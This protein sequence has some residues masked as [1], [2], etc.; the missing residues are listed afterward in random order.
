MYFHK[1][2][3]INKNLENLLN[4][5]QIDTP[6]VVIPWSIEKC[7]FD[8][9]FHSHEIHSITKSDCLVKGV[10]FLGEKNCNMGVSFDPLLNRIAF[11]RNEY[12][13][14]KGL[15]KSYRSFNN[16]LI[17]AFGEPNEHKKELE[18]F[19]DCIWRVSGTVEIHHY[20]MDRFGL[21]EHLYLKYISQ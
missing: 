17:E 10:T 16:A 5:V 6:R 21:G 4:G 14:H 7:E 18:E 11:S 8:K 15:V 13:G 19:E 20:V 1:K 3:K 12:Q 2:H 9:L